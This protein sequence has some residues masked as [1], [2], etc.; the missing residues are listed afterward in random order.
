MLAVGADLQVAWLHRPILTMTLGLRY[1]GLTGSGSYFV[2]YLR[3]PLESVKVC[4][5]KMLGLGDVHK[6]R[7]GHVKWAARTSGRVAGTCA[8]CAGAPP[9]TSGIIPITSVN[10][11]RTIF[12]SFHDFRKWNI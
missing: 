5:H 1:E 2:I 3:T 4:L 8:G 6:Y 11:P 10:I 7:E 9:S 12:Y